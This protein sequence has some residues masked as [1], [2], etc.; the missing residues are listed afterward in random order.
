MVNV[1]PT[2]KNLEHPLDKIFGGIPAGSSDFTHASVRHYSNFLSPVFDS[3][4]N[5]QVLHSLTI[6]CRHLIW[7]DDNQITWVDF[8]KT[9]P[10]CES[11]QC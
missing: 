9:M 1:T 7:I 3:F 10:G 5:K 11:F 2:L 8:G 4:G 6:W